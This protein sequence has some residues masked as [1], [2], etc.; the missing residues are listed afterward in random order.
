MYYYNEIAKKTNKIIVVL[1]YDYD[2]NICELYRLYHGVGSFILAL[3]VCT[4]PRI[5]SDILL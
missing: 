4:R 3:D 1:K 5:S 2:Y